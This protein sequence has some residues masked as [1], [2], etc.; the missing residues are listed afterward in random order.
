[1]DYN[2]ILSQLTEDELELLNKMAEEAKPV[3]VIEDPVENEVV[4]EELQEKIAEA[5]IEEQEKVATV[6]SLTGDLAEEIY[7]EMQKDA[8]FANVLRKGVSHVS[9][10]AVPY[11]L[12][13]AA[14]IGI[15]NNRLVYKNM[16]KTQGDLARMMAAETAAD[17][18]TDRVFDKRDKIMHGRQKRIS[19]EVIRNRAAV[20]ALANMMRKNNI[21][22][23]QIKKASMG[24]LVDKGVKAVKA[25]VKGVRLQ[26]PMNLKKD[27][28]AYKGWKEHI[29]IEKGLGKKVKMSRDLQMPSGYAEGQLG[30]A[31]TKLKGHAATLGAAT[32]ATGATINSM[33]D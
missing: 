2:E 22:P 8:S 21:G 17:I 13:G 1:M 31:S 28:K 26:N 33:R 29:K 30:D 5:P 25:Y 14:A 4:S 3:E 9:Q 10:N 18:A 12:G 32:L 16:K 15:S 6:E 20:H 7:N 11:A 27:V 24:N 19:H 23:E